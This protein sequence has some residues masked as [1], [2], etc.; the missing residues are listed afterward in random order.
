MMFTLVVELKGRDRR[1]S[2]KRKEIEGKETRRQ[3]GRAD[4]GGGTLQ[5]MASS[6][7]L[8]ESG[9]CDRRFNIQRDHSL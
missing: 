9:K 3:G 8:A 1:V 6:D 4:G 7:E 5:T 2:E